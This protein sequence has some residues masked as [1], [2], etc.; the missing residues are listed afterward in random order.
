MSS[1]YKIL[2]RALSFLLLVILLSA[3][4]KKS[5]NCGVECTY[6]EELIFQTG[7]EGATLSNGEY[8]N[9]NFTGVDMA[10]NEKSDWSDLIDH[11]NIGFVEVGYEDGS[12]NQRSASIVD[13]PD[14]V[15]N[16]VL[17][18]NIKEAH[19]KEGSNKKGRVQL[20]VHDNKCIKELY[21]EISLKF[22]PDLA[23]I[24][25]SSDKFYWFTL[26]EFWNNG[27]WTKEKNTFRVSVNLYK[28]EGSG[29]EIYFRVKSDYKNCKT[30]EWKE[31]WGETATAFPVI[32]GE[33]MHLELYLKEGDE[34][35]GRFMLSVTPEGG[36]K[37]TLFDIINTTQHPKEK[38]PDGF[39]HFEVAKM[40]TSEDNINYMNSADKELSVFWDNLRL[41]INKQP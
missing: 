16:K 1:S 3:C 33:W 22:H 28:E 10:F 6:N 19:I 7:F 26:F 21:E 23:Y 29:N 15:G 30:C 36:S 12:D 13:D 39:T 11:P 32:Y 41:T 40:Y 5:I 4:K 9:A 35:N 38:C 18:F 31:V 24:K 17:K 37:I 34:N 2:F 8:E 27:A 14:S 25:E 20:S